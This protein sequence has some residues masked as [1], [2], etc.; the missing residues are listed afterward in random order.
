MPKSK[1]QI[2]DVTRSR[3]R[4][5]KN[6]KVKSVIKTSIRKFRAISSP[7]EAEKSYKR[8]SSILDSAARKKIIHPNKAARKK[9]RL[10]EHLEKIKSS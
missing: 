8:L 3:I 1:S 7:E 6:C 5:E 2:K 4:N 10:H 9:S